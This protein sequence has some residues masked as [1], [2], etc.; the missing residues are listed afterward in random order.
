MQVSFFLTYKNDFLV[1]VTQN[2][3]TMCALKTTHPNMC[4][5]L[6]HAILKCYKLYKLRDLRITSFIFQKYDEF[7]LGYKWKHI[8]HCTQFDAQAIHIVQTSKFSFNKI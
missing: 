1:K 7:M 2:L 3:F 5:N 8:K 4:T 6:T